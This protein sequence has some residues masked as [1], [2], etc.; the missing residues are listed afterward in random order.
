V[1]GIVG[2]TAIG[3]HV[4]LYRYRLGEGKGEGEDQSIITADRR[5]RMINSDFQ[6]SPTGSRGQGK[7]QAH[8]LAKQ[9]VGS[10]SGFASQ[11]VTHLT[12]CHE[13]A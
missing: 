6:L 2:S 7:M 4:R 12:S 13:R 10:T 11:L 5:G 9:H 8:N 3:P 1:L